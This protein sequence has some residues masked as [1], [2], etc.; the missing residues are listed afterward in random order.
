MGGIEK[1][2][3]DNLVYPVYQD[4][5]GILEKPDVIIDFC[6]PKATLSILPFAIKHT[7]PLV[8]ATTGFTVEEQAKIEEAACYIPILQSANMCYEITLMSLIASELSKEL[9]RKSN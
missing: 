2:E 6:I 8:I 4:I 9:V 7:V 1:Q 5:N 3:H